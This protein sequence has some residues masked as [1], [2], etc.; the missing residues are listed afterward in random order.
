MMAP[1]MRAAKE[2]QLA[3]ATARA[4]VSAACRASC[5]TAGLDAADAADATAACI[6]CLAELSIDGSVLVWFAAVAPTCALVAA[7]LPAVLTAPPINEV[8]PKTISK[9]ITAHDSS[10]CSHPSTGAQRP[11]KYEPIKTASTVVT[12]TQKPE[13]NPKPCKGSGRDSGESSEAPMAVP[14]TLMIK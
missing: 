1:T 5:S 8:I 7:T 10:P 11:A 12:I 4:T 2:N 13:P 14:R 9:V 3:R 6:C